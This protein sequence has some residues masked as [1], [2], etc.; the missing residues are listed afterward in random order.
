MFLLGSDLLRQSFQDWAACTPRG[1][2]VPVVDND[3]TAGFKTNRQ[4][5]RKAGPATTTR[6]LYTCKAVAKEEPSRSLNE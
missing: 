2:I 6:S 1:S 3:C 4:F 5:A